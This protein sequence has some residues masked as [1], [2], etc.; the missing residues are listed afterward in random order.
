MQKISVPLLLKMPFSFSANARNLAFP[1]DQI[2]AET[3]FKGHK[4]NFILYDRQAFK[5]C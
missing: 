2:P 5:V 4:E 1:K 3:L